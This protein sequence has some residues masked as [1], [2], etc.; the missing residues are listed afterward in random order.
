MNIVRRAP[1]LPEDTLV[2]E[3]TRL[4]KTKPGR[5]SLRPVQAWA[6]YELGTYGGLF[7]PVGVGEG[8]TLITL[9]A[10]Y[11]LD[12]KRPLLVLP[13]G[14][15]EKTQRDQKELIE[16][17]WRI[18]RNIKMVSYEK[19]GRITGVDEISVFKPDLFIFDE[20]HKLKDRRAARTRRVS[21]AMH[22][23]P[24][25]PVMALSGTMMRRSLM[26]F[27]HVLRWCLKDKAPVPKTIEETEEW[28]LA[29]DDKVDEEMRFPPGDLLLFATPEERASLDPLTAAR[30][31]FQRRLLETPGVVSALHAND[32]DCSLEI[33]ALEYNMAPITSDHFHTLRR[34]M[35]TP[36]GW[37]LMT[38]AE[39]HLHAKQLA[40]GFHSVWEPRP[41]EDWRS[42]RREWNAFVREVLTYSR[43]L[44]SPEQ[45]ALAADTGTLPPGRQRDGEELLAAWRRERD[46]PRDPDQEPFRAN[47]VAQWHDDSAL[48]VAMDWAKKHGPGVIWTEHVPFAERLAQMSGLKYYGQQGL[49]ADGE[50]IDDADPKTCVIASIDANK[51]GRNLQRKWS[52]CLYTSAPSSS[53]E[54]EQSIGRFHRK[55]QTADSVEA[56]V[57]LGCAEHHKAFTSAIA[58]ARAVQDTTGHQQRLLIATIDWPASEE[59]DKKAGAR[60]CTAARPAYN[61]TDNQRSAAR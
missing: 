32:T 41:P 4:L 45:V 50:F 57:L 60:W 61:T 56:W 13:A 58:E 46:R 9:L 12:A 10:P 59:I 7:G 53:E 24:D 35:L 38:G 42:A 31:G 27:A 51:E 34:K 28:A 15:I 5:M 47:V 39:V 23:T 2:A 30:R 14:L 16:D 43:T 49:A 37:E 18:P 33:R 52:R 54:W 3:L 48:H 22:E 29:L 6:L 21:R 40:L 20:V 36:D 55:G 19:L 25:V 8:K 26:D 11:I 44:D 1:N 17:G